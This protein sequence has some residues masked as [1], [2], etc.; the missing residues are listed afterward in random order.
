VRRKSSV[1]IRRNHMIGVLTL[2][3]FVFND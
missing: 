1:M 2:N 3:I